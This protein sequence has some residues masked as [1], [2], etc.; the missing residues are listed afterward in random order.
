MFTVKDH[1]I[2][3]VLAQSS[4]RFLDVGGLHNV[5]AVTR[6]HVGGKLPQIGSVVNHENQC[7]DSVGRRSNGPSTLCDG[8]GP[9]YEG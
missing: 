8:F 9:T 5:V 1:Q 6:Q 2:R 7:G 4:D 3:G